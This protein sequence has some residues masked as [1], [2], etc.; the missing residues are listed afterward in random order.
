MDTQLIEFGLTEFEG[1]V[2]AE[3]GVIRGVS[4]I[5]GGVQAK[6][7]N[8]EVD[9]VT[10]E[11]MLEQGEK[12]GKVPVKW[13]HK[14]G[15]DAVNGYLQNFRIKGQKLL[16]D[17]HLLKSHSQ[18]AHAME[19]V[20]EMPGNVGLSAS[21]M[22]KNEKVGKKEFARCEDLISVDLVASPAANPSGM[23]EAKVDKGAN[24]MAKP[25][26]PGADPN[27]DKVVD[28]AA[29]MGQFQQFAAS[30]DA[31]FT[32]L[33][34]ALAP[35][36]EEEDEEEEEEVD[37]TELNSIPAL[38]QYFE[39][40]LDNAADAAQRAEDAAA[41]HDL[42]SHISQLMEFNTE[43]AEQNTML[44][45]AYKTLSVKTKSTVEFSA[46]A[47][48]SHVATVTSANG[49][50]LTEFEAKVKEFKDGGASDADA[51]VKACTEH[52]DLHA[53]HLEAKGAYQ[54]L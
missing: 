50:K 17:W 31:R 14:S 9:M 21:F 16:A 6:G 36:E 35:D 18:Y 40:R 43:L 34:E 28:F 7:H 15:A 23:F 39:T 26:T 38:L 29:F 4:V 46:G 45:E 42:E 52:S 13:N 8:L 44:A 22:G 54:T 48:G 30:I 20:T 11:Q 24:D 3:A 10:L 53:K 25:A 5:T 41:Q 19:M 27:E 32:Q 33:E 49:K 47:D 2:D 37:A 51:M 1:K 12:K